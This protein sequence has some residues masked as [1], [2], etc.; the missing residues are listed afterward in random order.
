MINRCRGKQNLIERT[1]M[2][3]IWQKTS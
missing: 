3:F 1:P 2:K